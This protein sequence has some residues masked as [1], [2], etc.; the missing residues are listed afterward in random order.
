MTIKIITETKH[1]DNRG[2]L[3]TTFTDYDY[4]I[5]FVQDKISQSRYGAIRGFHGDNKTY[6]LVTCIYGVMQFVTFDIETE[7]TT[8]YLL[9]ANNKEV[10]SI[11]VEPGQLNAHQCLSDQCIMSYKWSEYYTSPEDQ[12]T[13]KYDDPTIDADWCDTNYVIL[14]HRDSTAQDF[15]SQKEEGVFS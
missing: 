14:S 12:W 13:V 10:D 8:R 5:Q 3:Y 2:S 4:D 11:L 7:K 9:D 15:L 1:I 6:K